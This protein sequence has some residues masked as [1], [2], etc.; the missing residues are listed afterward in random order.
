[1]ETKPKT[2]QEVKSEITQL[3]DSVVGKINSLDSKK[4]VSD[5][6]FEI[7]NKIIANVDLSKLE[8]AGTI[9][10]LQSKRVN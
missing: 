8:K 6:T 9:A 10:Y 5:T 7:L 2:V 3:V 1:M 4:E